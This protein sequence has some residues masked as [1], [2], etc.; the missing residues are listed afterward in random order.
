MSQAKASHISY[1]PYTYKDTL[2]STHIRE[3]QTLDRHIYIHT[4]QYNMQ[5]ITFTTHL[6]N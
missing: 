5:N 4:T 3:P 6:H 1:T 2:F